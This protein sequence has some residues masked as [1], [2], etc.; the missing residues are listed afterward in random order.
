MLIYNYR[1]PLVAVA[2][3]DNCLFVGIAGYQW[4]AVQTCAYETE[5]GECGLAFDG[6]IV[7]SGGIRRLAADCCRSVDRLIYN[8]LFVMVAVQLFIVVRPLIVIAR[9]AQFRT[10]SAETC[11]HTHH[12]YDE[13]ECAEKQY[14]EVVAQPIVRV[15]SVVVHAS[16]M[17]WTVA[18]P[19]WACCMNIDVTSIFSVTRVVAIVVVIVIVIFVVVVFWS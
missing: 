15:N 8:R 17:F 3:L 7:V 1:H 6:Q 4:R 11:T 5:T 12:E 19:F 2:I 13:Y 18:V 9:H 16:P 10:G 14:P